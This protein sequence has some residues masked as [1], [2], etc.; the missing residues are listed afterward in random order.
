MPMVCTEL[1]LL[2][3]VTGTQLF[4]VNSLSVKTTIDFFHFYYH[5][6]PCIWYST[7]L[8]DMM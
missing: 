8:I 1:Y 3:A 7:L 5:Y 4:N 2:K 6:I